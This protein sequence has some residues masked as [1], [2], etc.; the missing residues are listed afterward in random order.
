MN[1]W[2]YFKPPWMKR[3]VAGTDFKC[4]EAIEDRRRSK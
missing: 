4:F 3:L 2:L 1:K